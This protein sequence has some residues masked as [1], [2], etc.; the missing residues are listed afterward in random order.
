MKFYAYLFISLSIANFSLQAM[1]SEHKLPILS[2]SMSP[3][4]WKNF[5]KIGGGYY[6]IPEGLKQYLKTTLNLAN[7]LNASYKGKPGY[8]CEEKQQVEILYFE[9][10]DWENYPEDTRA[11]AQGM[12]EI[13]V[14]ILLNLLQALGINTDLYTQITGG[15]SDCKG[16]NFFKVAHYDSTKNY[17]GIPWHKD[18]RWITV[19]FINQEGLQGNINGKIVDIRPLEGYFFV[20]L[21]V[22]FEAFINDHEKLNALVHQ[23][24]QVSKDRVSFGLFSQGDYPEK[25][26]YQLNG[27]AIAWKDPEEMKD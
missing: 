24:Q 21:G 20:N 23:V 17:P 19:L 22:F 2:E 18:I 7:S 10:K 11:L 1:E 15:L 27:D 3:K 4:D 5:A 9:K 12:S 6:P 14:I 26:F 13:A 16:Q 25:G 8:S